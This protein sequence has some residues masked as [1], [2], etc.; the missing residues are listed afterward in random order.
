MKA[1]ILGG[2]SGLGGKLAEGANRRGFPPLII[3]RDSDWPVDLSDRSSV[4]AL[5][6]KI[7]NLDD[8]ALRQAAYFFWNASVFEYAPLEKSQDWQSMIEINIHNPT[9]ILRAVV[10][11]KKSLRSPF[12]L[13][14]IASV[15]VWKARPD[16]AVYAASKAYQAQLARCLSIE[17]DHDLSGSQTTI[18]HPAGMRTE[19][20]SKAK[21]DTS[22]FMDPGEVAEII[23][24]EVSSQNRPCDWFNI[25][26][27][28]RQPVVSRENFS[29]ELAHDQLPRYNVASSQEEEK[30]E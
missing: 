13:V 4:E 25:L 22:E 16:M 26:R 2:S 3:G 27:E 12:H 15:A 7:R 18:V 19:L 10:D 17:L 11:R 5:C 14:V 9:S 1:W 29:P 28:N 30:N 8:V 20:F 21:V 6:Q 24:Q 23:W